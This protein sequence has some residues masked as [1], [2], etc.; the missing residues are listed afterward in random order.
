MAQFTTIARESRPPRYPTVLAWSSVV[1]AAAFVWL[2]PTTD[3]PDWHVAGWLLGGVGTM[4]CLGLFRLTDQ[5]LRQRP[6]Y[7]RPRNSGVLLYVAVL[8]GIGLGCVHAFR[9]AQWYFG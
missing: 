7:S 9:V 3:H 2:Y 6:N 5:R 8:A 1:A 4:V